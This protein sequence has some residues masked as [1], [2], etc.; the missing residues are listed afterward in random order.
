MEPAVVAAPVLCYFV[1]AE[2]QLFFEE[3]GTGV[4]FA[5]FRCQEVEFLD[6]FHVVELVDVLVDDEFV[7][8]I[9]VADQLADFG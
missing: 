3:G 4:E 9:E 7:S 8:S 5:Q 2:A 6:A 1:V